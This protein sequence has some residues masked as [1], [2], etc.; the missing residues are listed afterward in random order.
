MGM[1]T[2][3]SMLVIMIMIMITIM[4]TSMTTRLT[5]TP[6]TITIRSRSSHLPRLAR[7]GD[8]P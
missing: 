1:L 4:I 7:C 3:M 2:I 8:S 5:G 6:S